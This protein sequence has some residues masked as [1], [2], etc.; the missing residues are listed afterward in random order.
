MRQSRNIAAS[1]MCAEVSVTHHEVY[2]RRGAFAGW[3]ANYGLW[4]WGDEVL[5]GFAV[6]RIGPKGNIHELDREH[7]FKPCQARSLD[8][9][10]TW[11][12]E[13]FN[14]RVPGGASL[15]A[16]EH[17]EI[18]LKVRPQLDR[19]A[20]LNA[21]NEPIDFTDPETIVMCART[22]LA[23]DSVS[24]FYVSRSRGRRWEGPFAFT[25]LKLPIAART[26]IVALGPREALFLLSTARTDGQEGLAFCAR[27][28]DGG[29]SF[30]FMG[31]VG[32]E[33]AGHRIMPS[34]TRMC[35][36]TVVTAT[37]CADRDGNGL[38]EV[39]SSTDEGRSWIKLG[40]A[41]D[42][43]GY[44]G[45]PRALTVLEDGRLALAY[46]CRNQPFGI[47]LR[48]SRDGGQSWGDEIPLRAD[49]GTSDIGY[50]KAVALDGNDLLIVYY[51]NDG[52]GQER[53]I[54]A[55][56]VSQLFQPLRNDGP[57][58]SE[59]SIAPGATR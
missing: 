35:D 45:N 20:D 52:P 8:G 55:S 28:L 51:F 22:G 15:S 18:E 40:A 37:R 5:S 42:D 43:T 11:Q 31:F 23:E 41:V 26:D 12:I 29:R 1:A 39:F 3:P 24:W 32:D 36:G 46:G 30:E 21:L 27:T 4:A 59:L 56:R 13:A 50:P 10:Q 33:P 19:T 57:T 53:Y 6:G 47:R 9:G 16:D 14:G 48:L 44:G 58:A 2:R 17:L 25:G 7:P 34:S 54:A 49:G 38:I